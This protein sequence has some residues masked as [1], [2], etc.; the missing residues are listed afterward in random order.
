[1]IDLPNQEK[2][3]SIS[4]RPESL[5]AL[6]MSGKIFIRTGLSGTSVLG[7]KWVQLDLQQIDDVKLLHVSLSTEV[8]WAVDMDGQ[9]YF[10]QGPLAAPDPKRKGLDAAWLHVDSVDL[11]NCTFFKK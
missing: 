4:S 11:Q 5:W 9:I 1:P 10:R 7:L 8:V 3:I 2:L 6:T